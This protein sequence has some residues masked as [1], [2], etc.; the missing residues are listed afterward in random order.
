MDGSGLG[1]EPLSWQSLLSACPGHGGIQHRFL[2]AAPFRPEGGARP[3][4]YGTEDAGT[5]PLG[6]SRQH[7]MAG[8]LPAGGWR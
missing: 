5:G 1:Y 2:H 3:C 4:F 7:H 8:A 6:S